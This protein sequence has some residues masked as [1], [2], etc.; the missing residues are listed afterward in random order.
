MKLDPSYLVKIPIQNSNIFKRSKGSHHLYYNPINHKTIV[1][2]FQKGRDLK[3]GTF[4]S[5]LKQAEIDKKE[6]GL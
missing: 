1:I 6:I 4:L 2:P 3:K 5:I